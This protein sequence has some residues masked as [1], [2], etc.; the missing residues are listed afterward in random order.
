MLLSIRSRLLSKKAEKLESLNLVLSEE[1]N[2][3]HV[4]VETRKQA[5]PL[6]FV[7]KDAHA[8]SL[9]AHSKI[10]LNKETPFEKHRQSKTPQEAIEGGFHFKNIWH[11][12]KKKPKRKKPKLRMEEHSKRVNDLGGGSSQIVLDTGGNHE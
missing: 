9:A 10:W 8:L 6:R 3:R 12:T 7:R 11:I 5:K 1:S 4:K 2:V